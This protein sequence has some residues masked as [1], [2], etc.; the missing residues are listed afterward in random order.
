[1]SSSSLPLLL[2]A[3]Q[4]LQ[5]TQRGLAPF[6]DSSLRTVERIHAG[7][8]S[9]SRDQW[10]VIARA[11]H[12]KDPDLA[13]RIAASQM[14]TLEQFGIAPPSPPPA[15]PPV[16]QSSSAPSSRDLDS[17]L[18]AAA[19][20]MNAPPRAARPVIVAAFVKARD[21]GLSIEAVA[22]ALEA[23]HGMHQAKQAEE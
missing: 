8:S 5:L 16:A 14:A 1:M 22:T 18:C 12:A 6:V 15:A 13:A 10:A 7:R 23:G 11:V 3:R 17:L 21:L 20:A 2:E 4:V 9:L 19:D